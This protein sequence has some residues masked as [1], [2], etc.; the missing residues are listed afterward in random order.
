[1]SEITAPRVELFTIDDPEQWAQHA[2]RQL[3]LTDVIDPTNSATMGAGFARYNSGQANDWVV[4]YDEVLVV[5]KGR[6]T[7]SSDHGTVT[8]AAGEMIFMTAGTKVRYSAEEN[9][10]RVAF[11]TYPHW[12]DVHRNSGHA[13]L[14][15]T[16]RVVG[17]DVVERAMR[18]PR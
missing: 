17:S 18:E 6:F 14:L 4:T 7:V 2:D 5:T 9:D 3:F 10:T 15:D 13:Y 8:A 11:V 16:F 1:M 12:R